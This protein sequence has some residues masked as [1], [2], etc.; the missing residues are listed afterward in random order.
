MNPCDDAYGGAP[1]PNHN[2]AAKR[3]TG[4][5]PQCYKLQE[6]S[7]LIQSGIEDSKNA[8]Q[9]DIAIMEAH[10]TGTA[11]LFRP[12]SEITRPCWLRPNQACDGNHKGS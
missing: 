5:S 2:N 11:T 8:L 1:S 6:R 3:T 10:K 12:E 9:E 7:L 4:K